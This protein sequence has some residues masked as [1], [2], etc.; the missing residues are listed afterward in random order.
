MKNIVF[1]ILLLR[2]ASVVIALFG[3]SVAITITGALFQL[4]SAGDHAFSATASAM[5][6]V[7]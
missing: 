6:R 2:D 7:P 1:Q 4:R 5:V 3:V